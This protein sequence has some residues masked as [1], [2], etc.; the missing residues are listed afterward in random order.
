MTLPKVAVFSLAVRVFG[1]SHRAQRETVWPK[2]ERPKRLK[3]AGNG[4]GR[5]CSGLRRAG[6]RL[7][8]AIT[9]QSKLRMALCRCGELCLTLHGVE[10]RRRGRAR[11]SQGISVGQ[12]RSA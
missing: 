7:A 8:G 1:K 6:A 3:G 4:P 12:L 10:A 9:I 5:T 2:S 11:S